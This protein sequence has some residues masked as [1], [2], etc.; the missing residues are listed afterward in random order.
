MTKKFSRLALACSLS[1]VLTAC[2]GGSG[3]GP[4]PATHSATPVPVQPANAKFVLFI[5]AIT[6]VSSASA[7]RRPMDFSAST[8]SVT[9][10][11]GSKIL[12]TADVSA[13][14]S[15]CSA[16]TGGGRN[17]TVTA[18]A[19]TGTDDFTITAYDQPSGQGNAIAQGTVQA[20][21]STQ[22]TTVNVAVT[23]KIVK[24]AISLSNPYPPVGTA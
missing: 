24:I 23:G 6:G 3:A 9:I 11:V 19:Q 16:A 10:A 14:S 17:C 8:R 5:P 21:I 4:L 20:T 1:A 15:L 2:G 12:T 22:P 13:S 7:S 18:V